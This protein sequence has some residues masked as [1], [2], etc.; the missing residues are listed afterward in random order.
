MNFNNY[1][2]YN[3]LYNFYILINIVNIFFKFDK[4]YTCF[5]ITLP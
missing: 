3:D 5:I 1:K 4:S 2:V